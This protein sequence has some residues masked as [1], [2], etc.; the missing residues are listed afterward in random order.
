MEQCTI[1]SLT[2]SLAATAGTNTRNTALRI[3]HR[4]LL[5]IFTKVHQQIKQCQ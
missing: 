1:M 4:D 3:V 5:Y 2:R